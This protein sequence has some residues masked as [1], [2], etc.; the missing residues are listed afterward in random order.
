MITLN[1][2]LYV[3]LK[4]K[5]SQ[6]SG[7]NDGSSVCGMPSDT[8]IYRLQFCWQVKMKAGSERSILHVVRILSCVKISLVILPLYRLLFHS[9]CT[10][11]VFLF[12]I[13]MSTV[14]FVCCLCNT[15]FESLSQLL[16]HCTPPK[17][18][19]RRDS[20]VVIASM[21]LYFFLHF[22][23]ISNFIYKLTFSMG[24]GKE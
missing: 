1:V 23:H 14:C 11:I 19:H 6:G 3:T 10:N 21:Q 24:R 4:K 8:G 5:N 2:Y 13:C 22:Q 12:S 16:G 18:L 7:L 9:L 15:Q 20:K 17:S